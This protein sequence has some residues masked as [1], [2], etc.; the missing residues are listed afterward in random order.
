MNKKEL[1]MFFENL[2]VQDRNEI[3]YKKTM[4]KEE[5]T[6]L[7]RIHILEPNEK[8]DVVD[9]VA[10]T[11]KFISIKIKLP[12]IFKENTKVYSEEKSTFKYEVG[13]IIE[14]VNVKYLERL[15]QFP[16]HVEILEEVN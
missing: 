13:D 14:Q 5:L 8:K 4:S 3:G 1:I 2:D 10:V 16:E 11:E 12:I 15:Q 9:S 7:Y 6:E